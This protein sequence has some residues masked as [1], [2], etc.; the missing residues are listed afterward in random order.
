LL[1]LGQKNT[2]R[3]SA[4]QRIVYRGECTGPIPPSNGV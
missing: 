3:N 2:Y 4:L 1:T